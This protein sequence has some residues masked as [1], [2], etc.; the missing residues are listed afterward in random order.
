MSILMKR[1]CVDM[2]ASFE[3]TFLLSW[4]TDRAAAGVKG[5]H[6]TDAGPCVEG[7]FSVHLVKPQSDMERIMAALFF[8]SASVS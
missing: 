6:Q 5:A 7:P 4:Y 8:V 1:V 2:T 3:W